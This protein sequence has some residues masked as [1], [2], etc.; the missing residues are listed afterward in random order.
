MKSRT[1]IVLKVSGTIAG[2]HSE[3]LNTSKINCLAQQIQQI[4][5]AYQILLVV[6]G[7]N[8]IRGAQHAEKLG[9]C[10]S[11]AHQLG[12][13]ATCINGTLITDL[14]VQAGLIAT[15]LSALICPDIADKAHYKNIQKATDSDV[16]V[17]SGGTGLPFFSTD[18]AAIVRA[19]EFGAQQVFKG[20][21][22]D[23]IYS[24]NPRTNPHAKLLTKTTFNTVI[25]QSLQVMDKTAFVLAQQHKLTIKIFNI[26]TPHA[27]VRVLN[28]PAFGSTI[29]HEE[30]I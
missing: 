12:M 13:L 6:G 4:K 14:F 24:D 11:T 26:F 23:G 25:T 22:V 9:I 7:G 3:S 15:H 8:I 16:I 29:T 5:T 20:T 18:T 28:E 17:V 30:T 19:L 27:L 21:D 10:A 1:K 2:D